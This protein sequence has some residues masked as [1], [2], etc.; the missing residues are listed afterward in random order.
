MLGVARDKKIQI[1]GKFQPYDPQNPV[2]IL[3]VVAIIQMRTLK[4]EVVKVSV[5]QNSPLDY[6]FHCLTASQW[7]FWFK[8]IINF[9]SLK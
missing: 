8:L 4:A 2:Q 9:M 1:A 3:V 7:K 6:L 5:R